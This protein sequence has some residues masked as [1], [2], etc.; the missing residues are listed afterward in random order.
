MPQRRPSACRK[1][2]SLFQLESAALERA[3]RMLREPTLIA[4]ARAMGAEQGRIAMAALGELAPS[5]YRE[6]LAALIDEQ[7][8]REA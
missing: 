4:E 7:L 3:L 1:V 8:R 6:S 2:R 5:V